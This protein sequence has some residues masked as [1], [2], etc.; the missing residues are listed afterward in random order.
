MIVKLVQDVRSCMTC[1]N[2]RR[3]A[4]SNK[5]GH[6]NFMCLDSGKKLGDTTTRYSSRNLRNNVSDLCR[7]AKDEVNQRPSRGR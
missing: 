5:I 2:F 7:Y 3:R 1:P 6:E 4:M